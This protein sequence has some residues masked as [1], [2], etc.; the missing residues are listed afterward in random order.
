MSPRKLSSQTRFTDRGA[1][2]RGAAV[3]AAGDT[4]ARPAPAHPC[5][6]TEIVAPGV[7]GSAHGH[8][9]QIQVSPGS[10]SEGSSLTGIQVVRNA[11]KK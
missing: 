2:G 3:G 1:Q 8:A 9:E 6:G 5:T 11:F 7:D 4:G 10:V